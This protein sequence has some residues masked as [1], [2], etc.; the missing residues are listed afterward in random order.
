MIDT[1]V[2]F[3]SY[4]YSNDTSLLAFNWREVITSDLI[5]NSEKINDM[6]NY[7]LEETEFKTL[8]ILGIQLLDSYNKEEREG[9]ENE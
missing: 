3:V 8:T 9:K 7:L 6:Q 1:Y 4:G 2:Y 5:D